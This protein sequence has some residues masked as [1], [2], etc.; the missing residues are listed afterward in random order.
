MT[1]NI[2]V[3]SA[4]QSPGLFPPQNNTNFS[5]LKNIIDRDHIFNDT[6]A[7]GDNS[8][9]HRQ[10][11]M[12][13]RAPPSSLPTGTNSIAYTWIDAFGR[14]QLI[15]Y[16]GTT[17]VQL[18][19]GI[20]AAVNFDGT[21]APGAQMIRSQYNVSSVVKTG[22][23]AYNIVFTFPMPNSDYIIQCTGMR[24][25]TDDVCYG[26]VTGAPIY[27]TSVAANV[28]RVL[29]LG[30]NGSPRDVLMGNISVMR[31]TT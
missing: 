18:T 19:P 21:G 10:V 11:T 2:T 27:G 25:T 30:S 8:G 17:H 23:G 14:A 29:F 12:I 6:P 5:V 20:V 24:N 7:I 1:F 15:F 26:C 4:G 28:F 13:A 9:T 3:P 31:Y 16:D 22:T